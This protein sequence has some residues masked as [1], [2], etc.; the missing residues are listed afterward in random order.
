MKFLFIISHGTDFRGTPELVASIQE[1]TRKV[2]AEG[3]VLHGN[4]LKPP[5]EAVTVRIRNGDLL[6]NDGPASQAEEMIAA[7]VCV[8]CD[9][10]NAAVELATTHPMASAA[11]IEVR[12]VWE[13]LTL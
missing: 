2:E 3:V 6:K 8:N 11:T 4:P 10:L 13:E 7:Y 12:P 1:W 5:N 9:N